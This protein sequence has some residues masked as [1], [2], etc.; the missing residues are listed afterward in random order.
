MSPIVSALHESQHIFDQEI[1]SAGAYTN[2]W[3]VA[4]YYETIERNKFEVLRG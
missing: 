3:A 4:N 2:L 1:M